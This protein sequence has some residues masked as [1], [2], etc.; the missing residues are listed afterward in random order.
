MKLG[1]MLHHSI[2]DLLDRKLRTVL[3]L[4]GIV[5]GTAAL[6]SLQSFVEGARANVLERWD[7]TGL[8][9]QFGVSPRGSEAWPGAHR[10]RRKNSD[11]TRE[12]EAP[13]QPAA[14]A[15]PAN[16]SA[17]PSGREPPV[18]K[19][20][21]KLDHAALEEIRKLPGVRLVIVPALKPITAIA[22]EH[23]ISTFI[24]AVP[25]EIPDGAG[26]YKLLEGSNFL[27]KQES[28]GILIGKHLADELGF[29]PEQTA[30]GKTIRL[31]W[32]ELT[33]PGAAGSVSRQA[34]TPDAHDPA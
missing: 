2:E 3:T 26:I 11:G 12:G 19:N 21:R 31:R 34:P 10:R 4:A 15:D 13:P 28:G 30:L 23:E 24:C 17:D 33:L 32:E 16:P 1:D 27:P 20:R 22:G 14:A 25:A 18:E 5:I 9:S 7:Q 8:T 6:S 29:E